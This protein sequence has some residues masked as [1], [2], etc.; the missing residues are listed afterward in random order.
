MGCALYFLYDRRGYIVELRVRG[1]VALAL[2]RTATTCATSA[3]AGAE[4]RKMKMEP[5]C[6]NPEMTH[7]NETQIPQTTLEQPSVREHQFNAGR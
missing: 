6:E 1:E 2:R 4:S 5:E 7:E 3:G